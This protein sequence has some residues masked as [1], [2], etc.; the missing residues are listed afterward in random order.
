MPSNEVWRRSGAALKDYLERNSIPIRQFARDM[1][2]APD[3]VRNWQ[4]GKPVDKR[5]LW[6]LTEIAEY[7]AQLR[8]DLVAELAGIEPDRLLHVL[9][10]ANI[11]L[12]VNWSVANGIV[13]TVL[14][15]HMEDAQLHQLSTPE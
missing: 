14:R 4:K 9:H 13:P 3:T 7:P 10:M 8:R 15:Q 12:L 5:H 6:V 2:V 11:A 1:R